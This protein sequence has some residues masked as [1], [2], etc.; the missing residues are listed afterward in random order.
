MEW[1]RGFC[2]AAC[3][4]HWLGRGG[5]GDVGGIFSVGMQ[6][7]G[8]HPLTRHSNLQTFPRP[9]SPW[10]GATQAPALPYISVCLLPPYVSLLTGFP[11]LVVLSASLGD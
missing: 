4:A 11:M 3:S 7:L 6:M 10:M 2:A 8:Q 5:E 9:C 1:G